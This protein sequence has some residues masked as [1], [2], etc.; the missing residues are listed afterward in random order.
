MLMKEFVLQ[1]IIFSSY[2]TFNNVFA[3]FFILM[4][5]MMIISMSFNKLF[6]TFVQSWAWCEE[7]L[8]HWA[9]HIMDSA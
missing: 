7:E 5:F 4:I 8:V 6:L 2:F 9:I 1:L 3:E